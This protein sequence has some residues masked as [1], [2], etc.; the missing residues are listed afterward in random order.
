[1]SALAAE[2]SSN[3]YWSPESEEGPRV[4]RILSILGRQPDASR[5][6]FFVGKSNNDNFV[7]YRWDSDKASLTPFWIS[8]Q[9]VAVERRDPLTLAESMLYGIEMHVTSTGEWLVNLSAEAIRGRT[10]NLSLDEEDRP[11][12]TGAINGR[13][14]IVEYAYVQMAKGLLPD[15]EWVRLSGRDLKTNEVITEVLRNPT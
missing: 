2:G 12:L 1:M 6:A 15:V 14:C 9:N 13:L 4:Q 11:A 3:P 10:M 5:I 8:T 7:A